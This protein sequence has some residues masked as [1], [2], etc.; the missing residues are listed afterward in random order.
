MNPVSEAEIASE[1]EAHEARNRALLER[2]RELGAV[3]DAPRVIDCHFWAATR[4]IAGTLIAKLQEKGLIELS[5]TPPDAEGP[6]NVEG[7]LN[8]TPSFVASRKVTEELVR[9]AAE[10]GGQYDGWGTSVPE[11]GP[12]SPN[13][14][15]GAA[16]Q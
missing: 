15:H 3:L 1:V 11:A 13:R 4:E 12:T 2:I 5:A 7:Q 8:E 16:E 14:E 9:L 6:W 10:C